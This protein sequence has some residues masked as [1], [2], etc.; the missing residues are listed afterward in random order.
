MIFVDTGFFFALVSANDPDHEAVVEVL[1]S[2]KGQKLP[3]QLLTTNHVV[4]E[5]ITLARRKKD[6]ALAVEVGEALW[7]EKLARIHRATEEEERLAFDYLKRHR[8]RR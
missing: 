3:Q 8:P 6:H 7:S 1:E 2:L 4:F 5:T